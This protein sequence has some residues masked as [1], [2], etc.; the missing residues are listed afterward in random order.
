MADSRLESIELR[1]ELSR[2]IAHRTA[3]QEALAA[4]EGE[5]NLL[6]ADNG[7][8]RNE[9]L[10]THTELERVVAR[11]ADLH[12]ALNAV[13]AKNDRVE[14]ALA[15]ALEVG[16]GPATP[17]A[18]VAPPAPEAPRTAE[19]PAVPTAG[20]KPEAAPPA[21]SGR[22]RA[23]PAPA[24][25]EV[26]N[27]CKTYR[28][29]AQPVDTLKERILHP[30][31]SRRASFV[32]ALRDVSFDV[33]RG[34]FLGIAGANGSG[35]STLLKVLANV[36]AA[37]SG[38][39]CTAGRVAPFIELGVGLKPEFTAYDNVVIGGVMMGLEPEEARARYEAVMDFAGL[40]DF[41]QLKLKNY[42]SGMQVRLAFSVMAQVDADILLIDEVLAVGDAEFRAK[43]LARMKQLRAEGKTIVLVTH[44]MA[45][46]AQE[47]D[48]AILLRHGEVLAEGDPAVVARR[49][50]ADL[51]PEPSDM[52]PAEGTVAL[53]QVEP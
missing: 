33:H 10:R 25:I 49:Y 14:A 13:K 38:R 17:R 31:R 9:V 42:S 34:E 16:T 46:I 3:L 37:D 50:T 35:K 1:S 15:A 39:V 7:K 45:T 18:P 19:A 4:V 23:L 8:L 51:T 52:G 48:R 44:S 29:P 53:R 40:W 32:E 43:C 30:I 28:V 36:Y 2:T 27:L 47:C 12:G 26:R 22:L 21:E 5:R 11:C 41:T 24:V 20:P 6:R